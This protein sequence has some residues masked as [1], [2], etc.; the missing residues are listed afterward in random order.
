MQVVNCLCRLEQLNTE[1]K[2]CC[3]A[4]VKD[5]VT[6]GDIDGYASWRL[7]EAAALSDLVQRRLHHL[8]NPEDCKTAKKLICNLNKV[9]T[10]P[11]VSS[12]AL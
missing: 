10:C 1:N 2:Q 12:T 8:Q 4:L 9:E 7:K 6:L 3:R 5:L 11:S